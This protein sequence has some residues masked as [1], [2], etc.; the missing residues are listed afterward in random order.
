MTRIKETSCGGIVYRKTSQGHIEVLLLE[1]RNKRGFSKYVLPKGHMEET[2]TAQ[3]TALR[4]ICEETGLPWSELEMV[5]FVTKMTLSFIANN[6][7]WAPIIDKDV[8]IFLVKHKGNS[9]PK[10]QLSERFF[11]YRWFPVAEIPKLDVKPDIYE[12][13]HQNEIYL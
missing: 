9:E 4:E 11:G 1:W 6:I 13:M 10:P 2:E 7:E 5:K 3:E 12:I 8:Y